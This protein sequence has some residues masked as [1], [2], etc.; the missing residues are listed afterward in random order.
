[1]PATLS[2]WAAEIS[3]PRSVAG[4]S[5]GPISGR[6]WVTGFGQYVLDETDPFPEGYTLGDIWGPPDVKPET[7][8]T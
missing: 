1:M 7:A 6:A 3:E 2:R 5:V 4:S 8:T